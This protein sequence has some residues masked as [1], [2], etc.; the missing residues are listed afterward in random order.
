MEIDDWRIDRLRSQHSGV[1]WLETST[2]C[3]P[4]NEWGYK[5]TAQVEEQA[6]KKHITYRTTSPYHVHMYRVSNTLWMILFFGSSNYGSCMYFTARDTNVDQDMS[7]SACEMRNSHFVYITSCLN[8]KYTSSKSKTSG[9]TNIRHT[10]HYILPPSSFQWYSV[11]KR[12]FQSSIAWY[13]HVLYKR[14]SEILILSPRVI[15]S[16]VLRLIINIHT[17]S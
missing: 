14:T 16:I 6:S 2:P 3:N 15:I 13:L 9:K 11:S 17:G 5:C 12:I 4:S 1:Q 8:N 10:Q 7:A